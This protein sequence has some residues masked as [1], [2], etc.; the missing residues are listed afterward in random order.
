MV[1]YPSGKYGPYQ[2]AP[3]V[4]RENGLYSLYRFHIKDPI[5]F[6]K[7]LKVTVQQIGCGSQTKVRE[8]FGENTKYHQAAGVDE[9]SDICYFERSDDY[10]SVAYWY[11]SLPTNPFPRL[12]NREERIKDLL[13]EVEKDTPKRNDL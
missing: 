4:D 10:C 1:Y 2:G 11:Q 12:P 3:L 7:D 8:H 6:Q 5:Y 9:G 13:Y